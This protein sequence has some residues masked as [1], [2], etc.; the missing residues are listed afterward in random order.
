M[1]LRFGVLYRRFRPRIFSMI[2]NNRKPFE[3]DGEFY[4]GKIKHRLRDG[5]IVSRRC[6]CFVL[7]AGIVGASQ[8][9]SRAEAYHTA[10]RAANGT[11]PLPDNQS[12]PA[13]LLG[14]VLKIRG[15]PITDVG[16]QTLEVDDKTA[17]SIARE[18]AALKIA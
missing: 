6:L 13:R 9:F 1:L 7:N 3:E 17:D 15:F 18:F 2:S 10:V 16:D 8:N 12:N 5:R 4:A 14:A 11:L